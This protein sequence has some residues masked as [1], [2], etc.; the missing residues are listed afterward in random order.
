M[1]EVFQNATRFNDDPDAT[2]FLR[3][4]K[5]IWYLPTGSIIILKV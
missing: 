1:S 2:I 5:P 4:G 3:Y